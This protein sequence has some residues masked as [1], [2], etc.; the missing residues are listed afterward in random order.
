[1]LGRNV[2]W[3]RKPKESE[4]GWAFGPKSWERGE[5]LFFCFPFLL[6]SKPISNPF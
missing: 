5:L 6:N 1:M 2:D 3:A 4:E